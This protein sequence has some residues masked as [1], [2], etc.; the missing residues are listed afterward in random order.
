MLDD[1]HVY[2]QC[3][4][5]ATVTPGWWMRSEGL[6]H[7]IKPPT[8]DREPSVDP[9][10]ENCKVSEHQHHRFDVYDGAGALCCRYCWQPFDAC[11]K[12]QP[13]EDAR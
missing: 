11:I 1:G 4:A 9:N 8:R 6:V 3:A 2:L 10:Y 13:L 12:R 5:C 7:I